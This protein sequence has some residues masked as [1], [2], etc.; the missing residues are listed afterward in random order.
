MK[1]LVALC[2]VLILGA[3]VVAGCSSSTSTK[4]GD[5]YVGKWS[6]PVVKLNS[7]DARFKVE[8]KKNGDAYMVKYYYDAGGEVYG[9][10]ELGAS[11]TPDGMLNI[12]GGGTIS[13]IKADDTLKP[14]WLTPPLTLKRETN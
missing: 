10:V 7:F 6:S 3:V 11:L 14:S 4:A 13:H 5:V 9:L 8:I 12:G 1:K 2:M